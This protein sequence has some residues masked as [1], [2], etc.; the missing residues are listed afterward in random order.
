MEKIK[1]R[2][3]IKNSKSIN[4]DLYPDI[5]PITVNNFVELIKKNY[6][7]NLIFHRVIKGFMIQ[8]GGMTEDMK[9]KTGAKEI[10]GEFKSNGFDKN[11]LSHEVGVI[12]MAR[13]MIKDS[14]SSQFF[15]VT[16]NAK[17]LDGE[18]AAFGKVSDEESLRVA[19]E[20]ENVKT[21]SK[22]FHEDVPIEPIVIKNI[23]LI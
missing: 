15:I 21:G 14:A 6:F 8:G 10:K 13:T 7:D 1:I 16:G 18:Y 12:S 9:E 2:I 19:L 3:N 4:I 5:A 20:I 23:E 22:N 17:F 11:N